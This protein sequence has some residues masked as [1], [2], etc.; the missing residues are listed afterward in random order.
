MTDT[1]PHGFRPDEC[2][3]CRTL[4][5]SH[6][7]QQVETGRA[8]QQPLAGGIVGETK[9]PAV[10]PDAVYPPGRPARP[11]RSPGSQLALVAVAVVAIGLAVWAVA[12]AV[13]AILHLLELL[14]VAGVAGWVGYRLGLYR[15]RR[16]DP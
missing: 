10:Q 8:S 15:G 7:Q 5:G 1:C 16:R 2:L 14:V 12:G 6:P 4:K 11:P 9:R 13:F 3:I